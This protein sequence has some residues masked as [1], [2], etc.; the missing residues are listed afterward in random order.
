M[1]GGHGDSAQRAWG[2]CWLGQAGLRTPFLLFVL[3]WVLLDPR[4]GKED[5]EGGKIIPSL[6]TLF[7]RN[8]LQICPCPAVKS[9]VL[10]YRQCQVPACC[11][12]VAMHL[13][14]L[15]RLVKALSS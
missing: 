5:N 13:K 7:E 10:L 12:T 14:D 11:R 4:S 15:P 2:L 8:G 9:S 1:A 6:S 3:H